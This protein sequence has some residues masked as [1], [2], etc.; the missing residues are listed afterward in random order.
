MH[1]PGK[2]FELWINLPEQRRGSNYDG[3]SNIFTNNQPDTDEDDTIL[4]ESDDT[5]SKKW[6]I[7]DF[8]FLKIY[9]F[10]QASLI[11]TLKETDDNFDKIR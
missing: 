8:I 1:F 6:G 3:Q 2:E 5:S 10:L 7:F 11:S 4:E 9:C